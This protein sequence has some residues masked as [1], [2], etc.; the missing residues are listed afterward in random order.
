MTT[1]RIQRVIARA[2]DGLVGVMVVHA[3]VASR[4]SAGRDDVVAGAG[5]DAIGS[6]L[7][8]DEVIEA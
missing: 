6:P 8:R 1:V 7:R 5:R 2:T 3:S 4:P